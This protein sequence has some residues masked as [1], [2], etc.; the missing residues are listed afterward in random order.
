MY[1]THLGNEY[2]AL[3]GELNAEIIIVRFFG[4][5]FMAFQTHAVFGNII[6]STILSLGVDESTKVLNNLTD[7]GANFCPGTNLTSLEDLDDDT[8]I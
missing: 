2:A 6:S 5:F 1:I 4:I 8:K 3:R 7:C